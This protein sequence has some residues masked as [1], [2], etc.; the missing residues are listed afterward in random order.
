LTINHKSLIPLL[1]LAAA[2]ASAQPVKIATIQVQAALAGTKEGKNTLAGLEKKYASRVAALEKLQSDIVAMQNQMRSGSATM[3]QEAKDRLARDFDV[4]TKD[5]NRQKEDYEA[6][7]QQEEGSIV[8]AMGQK[9]LGVM[10]KYAQENKITIVIDVS[11]QGPVL[12]ADPALDITA[13]IEKRYDEAYPAPDAAKP[14]PPPV[15]PT[16]K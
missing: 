7:R 3:S 16:K 15:P 14:T 6:D 4:K 11:A 10:Q 9:L 5:F 13:E 1:L 12:W 8:G 2:A